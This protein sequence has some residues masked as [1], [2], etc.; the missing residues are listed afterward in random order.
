MLLPLTTYALLLAAGALAMSEVLSRRARALLAAVALL[1]VLL[2]VDWTL[3]AECLGA[4]CADGA[5]LATWLLGP[6]AL[7]LA[8]G[9]AAV[10]GVRRRSRG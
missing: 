9:V 3:R 5:G 8:L 4:W 2:L 6:A 10:D 1:Q 7:V